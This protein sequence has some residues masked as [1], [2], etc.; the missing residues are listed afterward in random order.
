M[1][2]AV[3][4]IIPGF[5][6]M[7][8][9]KLATTFFRQCH[10]PVIAAWSQKRYSLKNR[11][12][13]VRLDTFINSRHTKYVCNIWY[14]W[15]ISLLTVL[16]IF[17]IHYKLPTMAEIIL[18][19]SVCLKMVFFKQNLLFL[20]KNVFCKWWQWRDAT[21]NSWKSSC[22]WEFCTPWS[23]NANSIIRKKKPTIMV[24]Q[25]INAFLLLIWFITDR[26]LQYVGLS[27]FLFF[28]EF[29]KSK[30]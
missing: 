1:T 11:E 26:L 6:S 19:P 7:C 8:L 18:C 14:F 25:S 17:P 12:E 4:Q 27:K 28:T 9:P 23:R 24:C 21:V 3:A 30:R 20:N 22:W 16:H 10:S 13:S 2:R 5:P 29:F 15:L